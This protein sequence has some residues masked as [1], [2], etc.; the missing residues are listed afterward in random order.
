MDEQLTK[1]LRGAGVKQDVL[2]I[3]EDDEVSQK[4]FEFLFIFVYLKSPTCRLAL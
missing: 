1:Y 3:L 2:N 4:A